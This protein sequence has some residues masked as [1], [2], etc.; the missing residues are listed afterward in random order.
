MT[1]R[2]DFLRWLRGEL[3][4]DLPANVP[5]RVST[6]S[7]LASPFRH[8]CTTCGKLLTDGDFRYIPG[9]RFR[10]D[11]IRTQKPVFC[12][13]ECEKQL[14]KA[15]D[16]YHAL[17]IVDLTASL[18]YWACAGCKVVREASEVI[19][20]RDELY[21]LDFCSLECRD[22]DIAGG[23]GRELITGLRG[24]TYTGT[25]CGGPDCTSDISTYREP[26]RAIFDGKLYCST[27]CASKATGR[28][29]F[30]DADGRFSVVSE[31]S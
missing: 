28:R 10:G 3:V 15:F 9:T 23:W 27:E 7:F 19:A 5:A 25:L 24:R 16:T 13:V 6:S 26:D 21:R 18:T 12:S 20:L 8:L 29:I 22:K 31:R 1:S 17:R 2:N 11:E 4:V 14:R 30:R